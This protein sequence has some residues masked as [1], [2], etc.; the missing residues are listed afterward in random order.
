MKTAAASS[1]PTRRPDA[2]GLKR[3]IRAFNA[4]RLS[5]PAP[6]LPDAAVTAFVL[7]ANSALFRF[8]RNVTPKSPRSQAR[9]LRT[10]APA[11]WLRQCDERGEI[12]PAFG[13]GTVSL[14][15]PRRDQSPGRKHLRLQMSLLAVATSERELPNRADSP[16]RTR[17]RSRP[18][19]QALLPVRSLRL[20]PRRIQFACRASGIYGSAVRRTAR[21]QPTR[22]GHCAPAQRGPTESRPRVE[23]GRWDRDSTPRRDGLPLLRLMTETTAVIP[24]PEGEKT[25]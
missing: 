17:D 2:K 22:S 1:F 4:I 14:P 6:L 19:L 9:S 13:T 10:G 23:S 16:R 18:V 20:L 7:E 3:S 25:P 21:L 12:S 11:P 24:P 8:I 5:C 15:G